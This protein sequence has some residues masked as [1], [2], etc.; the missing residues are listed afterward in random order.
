MGLTHIKLNIANPAQLKRAV[1]LS[2]VVASGA[3]YSVSPS[4]LL[5]KLGVRPHSKRIF[6]LADGSEVTGVH[7]ETELDRAF[8]L[9]RVG[10]VQLDVSQSHKRPCDL[11]VGWGKWC[12]KR[13]VKLRHGTRFPGRGR[14]GRDRRA[15][16]G[17]A[18]SIVRGGRVA[19]FCR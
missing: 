8:R 9:C 11:S 2:V 19:F 10:N 4:A 16:L 3:V 1:E 18:S 17:R 6:T 15:G 7:Q 14:L 5:R 13:N 12:V